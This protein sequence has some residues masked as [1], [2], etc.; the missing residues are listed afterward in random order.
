[1][2]VYNTNFKGLKKITEKTHYDSR[3]YFKEILR[4]KFLKNKKLIFWCISKSKK[5]V[6]R[7]LHLQRKFRQAKFISVVKGKIFDVVVDLRR[8]SKTF[9]KHYS[10]ILS[11]KNNVSLFAPAGF[12]HGFCGLDKENIVLYGF[13]NYRSKKNEIGIIWN[14]K[15]LKI[16]WP[17]KKPRLSKKDKRNI[18]FTNFINR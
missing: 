10:L 4:N 17:V 13:T 12:A 3:G 15:K 5:N 2:K 16:K 1:M 18:T 8:G 6:L 7:G 14:D 9:G 11:E